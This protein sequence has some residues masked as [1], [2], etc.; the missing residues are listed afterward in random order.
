MF[1]EI[2]TIEK[3]QGEVSYGYGVVV[4]YGGWVFVDD[5]LCDDCYEMFGHRLFSEL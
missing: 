5:V 2:T 1:K 4:Q 3:L